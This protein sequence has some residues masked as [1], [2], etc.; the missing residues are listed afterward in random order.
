MFRCDFAYGIIHN[1]PKWYVDALTHERKNNKPICLLPHNQNL[2]GNQRALEQFRQWV[3][4]TKQE[5]GIFP[6]VESCAFNLGVSKALAQKHLDR[7][8]KVYRAIYR[9]HRNV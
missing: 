2:A 7:V 9:E 6:S 1:P 5:T 4:R 3:W 8:T